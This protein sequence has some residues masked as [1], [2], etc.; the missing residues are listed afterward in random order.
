MLAP[1]SFSPGPQLER[2]ISGSNDYP[3]LKR[4]PP[5][6][7]F[8]AVPMAILQLPIHVVGRDIEIANSLP[9]FVGQAAW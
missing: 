5:E 6:S 8:R 7:R 3:H 1:D 4:R 9:S 2:E